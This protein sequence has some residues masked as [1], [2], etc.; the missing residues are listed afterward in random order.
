M[1]C[2]VSGSGGTGSEI[3]GSGAV[4]IAPAA[5]VTVPVGLAASPGVIAAADPSSSAFSAPIS[6]D[7]DE[8][9]GGK[10]VDASAMFSFVPIIFV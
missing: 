8:T 6:A 2:C 3:G 9:G 4:S 10:G 5:I 1:S 7:A